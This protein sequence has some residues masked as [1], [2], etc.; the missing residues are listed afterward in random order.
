[1]ALAQESVS[2]SPFDPPSQRSS[3]HAGARP[4]ALA[5]DLSRVVVDSASAELE[6][7]EVLDG[8]VSLAGVTED[9]DHPLALAELTRDLLG[10]MEGRAGGDA[11]QDSLP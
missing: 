2:V 11:D 7:E 4:T 6:L 9:G 5:R 3:I 10:H 8:E 1:M